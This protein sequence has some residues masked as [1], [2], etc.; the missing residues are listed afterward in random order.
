MT[1]P[2]I[3]LLNDEKDTFSNLKKILEQKFFILFTS[4]PNEAAQF[5]KTN[6][7]LVSAVCV[8]ADL[9]QSSVS[10]SSQSVFVD[11]LRSV[12]SYAWS[13]HIP[14]IVSAKRHSDKVELEAM[15]NGAIDF[16]HEPYDEQIILRCGH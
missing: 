8:S 12:N 3:L 4:S 9:G 7:N 10:S 2:T 1:L 11:F 15:D 6:P 13:S 16:I 5:I 14:I